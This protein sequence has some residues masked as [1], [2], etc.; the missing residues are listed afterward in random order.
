MVRDDNTRNKKRWLWAF[1]FLTLGFLLLAW[2]NPVQTLRVREPIKTQLS[3]Y[4]DASL[5]MR[6]HLPEMN[7]LLSELRSRKNIR[8]EVWLFGSRLTRHD[9]ERTLGPADLRDN[10]SLFHRAAGQILRSPVKNHHLV[11]SDYDF[12]D[13][14]PFAELAEAGGQVTWG[15]TAAPSSSASVSFLLPDSLLPGTNSLALALRKNIPGSLP[16]VIEFEARTWAGTGDGVKIKKDLV[17]N[18]SRETFRLVFD[19]PMGGAVVMTVR[20][21]FPGPGG[22]RISVADTAVLSFRSREIPVDTIAFQPDYDV[23]SVV[24]VLGSYRIFN[25]QSH[26]LLKGGDLKEVSALPLRPQA[27]L[28]L[29]SPPKKVL[30]WAKLSGKRIFYFPLRD[31]STAREIFRGDLRIRPA[32][33]VQ[34]ENLDWKWDFLQVTGDVEGSKKVWQDAPPFAKSYGVRAGAGMEA[35]HLVDG[36]SSL[37]KQDNLIF[38]GLYPIRTLSEGL[39]SFGGNYL[40]TFIYNLFRSFQDEAWRPDFL[41]ARSLTFFLGDEVRFLDIP[42]AFMVNG[43]PVNPGSEILPVEARLPG[44][45]RVRV[46]RSGGRTEEWPVAFRLP[47]RE[48]VTD[49][50][51]VPNPLFF[52]K[53]SGYLDQLDAVTETREK[54]QR[55]NLSGW[56]TLMLILLFFVLFA[57][58]RKRISDRVWP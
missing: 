32:E 26:V 46:D 2:W 42:A 16:A 34:P 18:E 33:A 28:V 43:K 21:I 36:R 29:F 39:R 30:D 50:K 1:F 31:E 38:V 51:S 10:D 41:N 54:N 11:F 56:W 9:P 8:S 13:E 22:A 52:D 5:S 17:M 57:V 27:A 6:S 4:L 48:A 45:A 55:R 24:D 44:L 23:R 15:R 49:Q 35:F 20:L 19:A 7:R 3:L 14:V 12:S 53:I 37:F 47:I 40:E 58:F 25:V